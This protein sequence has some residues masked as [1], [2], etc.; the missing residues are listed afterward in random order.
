MLTCWGL[1]D[2]V[3]PCCPAGPVLRVLRSGLTPRSCCFNELLHRWGPMRPCCAGPTRAV[4]AQ[5]PCSCTAFLR[6]GPARVGGFLLIAGPSHRSPVDISK[7]PRRVTS[8]KSGVPDRRQRTS[9]VDPRPVG[10]PGSRAGA[11]DAGPA[12]TTHVGPKVKRRERSRSRACRRG[13]CGHRISESGP[14]GRSSRGN[15]RVEHAPLNSSMY[16]NI[17]GQSCPR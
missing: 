12:P 10:A 17:P 15:R 4:L 2:P 7:I 16:R 11:M 6:G 5:C 9:R 3:S 14:P 8:R 13:E 1:R